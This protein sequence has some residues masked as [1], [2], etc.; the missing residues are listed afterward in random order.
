MR[1]RKKV[2]TD[3]ESLLPSIG[4]EGSGGCFDDVSRDIAKEFIGAVDDHV[5]FGGRR[6]L[7]GRFDCKKHR[8]L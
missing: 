5:S 1:S 7:W 8:E 2:K 6:V 4:C 3:K